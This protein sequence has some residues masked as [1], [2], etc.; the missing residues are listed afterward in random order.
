[1][2]TFWSSLEAGKPCKTVLS[3][4]FYPSNAGAE[5]LVIADSLYRNRPRPTALQAAPITA[6]LE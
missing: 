3:L 6:A 5:P 2:I 1:M 4:K